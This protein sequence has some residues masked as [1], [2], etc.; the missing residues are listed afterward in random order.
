M[1][2][3]MGN[4][5]GK[6]LNSMTYIAEKPPKDYMVMVGFQGLHVEKVINNRKGNIPELTDKDM[7]SFI[8]K[9]THMNFKVN[10]SSLQE[11]ITR[12]SQ[13]AAQMAYID[14][15]AKG[16]DLLGQLYN[17]LHTG[18]VP[19]EIADKLGFDADITDM[20]RLYQC[21]ANLTMTN[22]DMFMDIAESTDK[23]AKNITKM[24]I[25]EIT[26]IIAFEEGHHTAMFAMTAQ[27]MSDITDKVSKAIEEMGQDNE[28]DE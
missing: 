19:Q 17:D 16:F 24:N 11:A 18:D 21:I 13:T 6:Q 10:A 8:K 4:L 15:I 2:D 22:M 12:V 1:S 3:E 5:V 20:D 26:S 9:F 25:P 27:E 14:A 28:G 7:E 23:G